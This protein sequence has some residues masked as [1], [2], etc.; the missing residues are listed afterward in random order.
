MPGVYNRI[1]TESYRMKAAARRVL[2]NLKVWILD[3]L[4]LIKENLFSLQPG[5]FFFGEWCFVHFDHANLAKN[6]RKYFNGD[7]FLDKPR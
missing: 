5:E 6:C 1:A 3:S 2:I 4:P 7:T